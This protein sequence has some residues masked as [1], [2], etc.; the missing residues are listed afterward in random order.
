MEITIYIK[1]QTQGFDNY[2]PYKEIEEFIDIKYSKTNQVKRTSTIL[3]M[4]FV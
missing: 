3:N 1:D 2:I 4:L